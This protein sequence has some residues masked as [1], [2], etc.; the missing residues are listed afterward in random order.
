M[1]LDGRST[2]GIAFSFS[3]LSYVIGYVVTQQRA[4]SATSDQCTMQ[5]CACEEAFSMRMAKHPVSGALDGRAT[6]ALALS[7]S[8]LSYVRVTS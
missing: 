1:T 5:V 6:V 4:E 3:T 8:T 7:F 2:A